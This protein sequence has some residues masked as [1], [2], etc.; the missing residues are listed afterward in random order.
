MKK[1]RRSPLNPPR[2]KLDAFYEKAVHYYLWF[3]V[4]TN[5]NLLSNFIV[6]AN[7]VKWRQPLEPIEPIESLELLSHSQS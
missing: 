6:G 4:V 7:S 3:V 1:Y 2:G 5:S